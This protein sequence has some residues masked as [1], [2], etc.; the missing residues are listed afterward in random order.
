MNTSDGGQSVYI[1]LQTID[2]P[3]RYVAGSLG[4]LLG[5]SSAL[6]NISLIVFIVIK[7]SSCNL[8]N[9][10][11]YNI[12]LSDLIMI[13]TT[14]SGAVYTFY[15]GEWRLGAFYCV[16]T[17][18]AA[19]A[20]ELFTLTN[21]LLLICYRIHLIVRPR[22]LCCMAN[23]L[24]IVLLLS[25]ATLG[26]ASIPV[27]VAV[28]GLSHWRGEGKPQ[29]DLRFMNCLLPKK[30]FPVWSFTFVVILVLLSQVV[31]YLYL[32]WHVSRSRRSIE[33][34]SDS[35]GNLENRKRKTEV[36]LA[37]IVM[38]ITVLTVAVNSPYLIIYEVMNHGVSVPYW[39]VLTSTLIFW[40][41]YNICWVVFGTLNTEIRQCYVKLFCGLCR[42]WI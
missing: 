15:V 17:Y 37:H 35:C 28:V 13:F 20:C 21:T 24:T 1:P 16:Y 23:R 25:L 42:S 38:I 5:L 8:H 6:G 14:K 31:L 10:F 3:A 30:E 12:A 33:E 27:A 7:K 40:I 36:L 18:G 2:S 32:C 41:R 39:V 26:S 22:W 19:G 29:F 11:I 9:A 4:L 34:V